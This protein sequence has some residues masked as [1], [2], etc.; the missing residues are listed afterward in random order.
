VESRGAGGEDDVGRDG[1]GDTR[2]RCADEGGAGGGAD[3][4]GGDADGEGGERTGQPWPAIMTADTIMTSVAQPSD[5]RIRYP[6]F[7]TSLLYHIC[8]QY[9]YLPDAY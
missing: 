1:S 9:L 5:E 2:R 7:S 4:V 8:Q 6:Y 3:I